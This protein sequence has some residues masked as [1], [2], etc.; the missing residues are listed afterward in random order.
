MPEVLPST[1]G[2]GL[3]HFGVDHG[4]VSGSDVILNCA[5]PQAEDFDALVPFLRRGQVLCYPSAHDVSHELKGRIVSTAARWSLSVG[6][7]FFVV[8]GSDTASQGTDFSEVRGITE[9][10]GRVG[11]AIHEKILSRLLSK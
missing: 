10:C 9:V 1:A 11:Q 4:E 6:E 8:H 3:L 5:P 2:H 7:D